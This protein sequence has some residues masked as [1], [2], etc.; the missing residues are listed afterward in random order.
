MFYNKISPYDV[1][2]LSDE[3]DVLR[4]FSNDMITLR[5]TKIIRYSCY[6]HKTLNKHF[7]KLFYNKISRYGFIK[8]M[9][10]E[11]IPQ[12]FKNILIIDCNIILCT[13]ILYSTDF[14]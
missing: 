13:T 2:P 1:L 3:F 11:S 8:L 6:T 7:L 4:I 14:H 10:F 9:F 12:G 5:N